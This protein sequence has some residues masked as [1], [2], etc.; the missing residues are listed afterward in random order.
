MLVTGAGG[1]IGSHL[2]ERLEAEGARV[3][4]LVHY[5]SRGDPGALAWVGTENLRGV[6]VMLGDLTDPWSVAEAVRD[7]DVVFHL[8]ALIPI[9]Y[10]YRAP[11]SFIEVNV[12]GTLNV[13]QAARAHGVRR[14][15]HTSTSEVYGT[16]QQV[17]ITESHPIHAQSPYAASKA[18][19]DELARSFHLSFDVPVATIRPFN[20]FG[21]RQSA[22]AVIPTIVAQAL[23]GRDVA[24]G[25]LHPTR[26]FTFVS[27]TVEAFLRV[28][29]APGAVG[30]TL[31]VGTGEEISI[32]DLVALV[33]KLSGA[34]VAVREDPQRIRPE[35]SEVDRLVCDATE[36]RRLTGWEPRVALEDGL[37]DTIEWMAEHRHLYR[38]REYTI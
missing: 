28:A 15:V 20:T 26:D 32:G 1:F 4:A 19:A 33:S 31:N 6:E 24:L 9:P 30:R 18:A 29:D 36:L 38:P 23:Q 37:R 7:R 11:G 3:R 34:G 8:G 35:G 14:V 13:L 25:S 12:H 16:A 22:R 2:V 10:S 17:P 5:N 21:P 27:D